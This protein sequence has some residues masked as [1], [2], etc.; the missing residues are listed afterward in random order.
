MSINFEEVKTDLLVIS[1]IMSDAF[2][3]V[4]CISFL[5]SVVKLANEGDENAK[6]LLQSI[7]H[8]AELS[9]TIKTTNLGV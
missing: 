2:Y 3:F 5:R 7:K 9:R 6:S 4:K 8:V 1:R